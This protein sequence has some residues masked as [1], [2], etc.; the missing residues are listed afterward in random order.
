[1]CVCVCARALLACRTGRA[2][3]AAREKTRFRVRHDK[4][5]VIFLPL[6]S[7]GFVGTS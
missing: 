6:S 4:Q 7:R 1:M 5:G 2:G 3:M